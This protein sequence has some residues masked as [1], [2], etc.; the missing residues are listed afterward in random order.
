MAKSDPGHDALTA[1]LPLD[2]WTPVPPA[3]T[4][5]LDSWLTEPGLLTERLRALS[6][7]PLRLRLVRQGLI[8]AETVASAPLDLGTGNVFVREIELCVDGT[9]LI[10]AQTLVPDA[11]LAHFPWLAELGDSPLGETLSVLDGIARAAFEYALLPAIHPLA[12]TAERELPESARATVPARRATVSLRG[13]PIL[14]QELFLPALG[15]AI[16]AAA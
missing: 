13:L 3:L 16:G 8:G 4:A 15:R 1:P 12:S 5:P 7:A 9:P 6:T 10:F 2:L 14:V 11:T